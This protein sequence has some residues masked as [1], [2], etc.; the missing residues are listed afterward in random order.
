MLPNVSVLTPLDDP[1]YQ[2]RACPRC[3]LVFK[4]F[5]GNG[6]DI[7]PACAKALEDKE[8]KVDRRKYQMGTPVY[9]TIERDPSGDFSVGAAFESKN[10]IYSLWD[11]V[12][13]EG[14]VFTH[15]G[16]RYTVTGQGEMVDDAGRHYRANMHKIVMV[17]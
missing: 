3:D 16:A 4:C 5:T 9:W 13:C 11:G 1:R 6:P 14:T 17:K 7:C 10:F 15:A 8:P 12:W 2:Y